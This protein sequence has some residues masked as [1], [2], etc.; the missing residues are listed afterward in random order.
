ME[1]G[2]EGTLSKTL[3]YEKMYRSIYYQQQNEKNT[4]NVDV[5]ETATDEEVI[6]EKRAID[7]EELGVTQLAQTVTDCDKYP[8]RMQL[9]YIDALVD[10]KTS[11]GWKSVY[12]TAA[13]EP[14]WTNHVPRFSGTIDYIF[15]NI[16][17]R[18]T[19]RITK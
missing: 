5:D 3:L 4:M 8:Q 19:C 9:E 11:I 16:L 6:A 13:E 7:I 10:Y 2:T 15:W 12:G 18:M 1:Y 17:R 14:L